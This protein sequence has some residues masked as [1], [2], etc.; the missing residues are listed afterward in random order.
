MKRVYASRELI[1]II[2]AD[3]W[4]RVSQS[5]AHWQFK[6]PTKPGRVTIVHPKR[7]VPIG[8]AHS[9][10]RQAGIEPPK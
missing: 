5:G 8:T 3:G 2:E 7:D 4:Y 10:F 1:R 9:V 6:H